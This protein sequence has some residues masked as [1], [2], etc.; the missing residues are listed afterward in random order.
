MLANIHDADLDTLF[1]VLAIIAF[2][3]SIYSFLRVSIEAGAALALL[4][5]L[6]LVFT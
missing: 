3:L 4:G 2:A 6:I 1:L 5:I